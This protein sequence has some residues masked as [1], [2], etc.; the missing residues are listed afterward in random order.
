MNKYELALILKPNLE[1]NELKSEFDGTIEFI[2]SNGGQ[3]DKVAEWGKR[4][5]A[6]EIQ[7]LTDGVYYFVNF[8]SEGDLP[9]EIEKRLRIRENVL[10]FLV[11]REEA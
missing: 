11:V 3:V 2:T 4:R 1:E 5:L 10:R 8:S 7:K 9:A 6:Y